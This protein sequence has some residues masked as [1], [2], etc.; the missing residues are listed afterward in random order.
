MRRARRAAEAE[1]VNGAPPH[2][3]ASSVARGTPPPARASGVRPRRACARKTAVS[4]RC[5]W[6]KLG[7]P[8]NILFKCVVLFLVGCNAYGLWSPQTTETELRLSSESRPRAPRTQGE[9]SAVAFT[10]PPH[11]PHCAHTLKTAVHMGHGCTPYPAA[12]SQ[13]SPLPRPLRVISYHISTFLD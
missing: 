10:G 5:S 3:T 4:N 6:V 12:A 1:S 2:S 9:E 11:W 8:R 7:P 13:L